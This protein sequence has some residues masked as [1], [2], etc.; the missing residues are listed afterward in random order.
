MPSNKETL[1]QEH[2]CTHLEQVQGYRR[3]RADE[4]A[5][6]QHHLIEA[7]FIGFITDTQAEKY[8]HIER[9]YKSD[10]NREIVRA[11]HEALERTPLWLLMR[12]GLTVRGTLLE[13][14]KPKPRSTTT[15]EQAAAYAQN[16]FAFKKEYLYNPHTVERVDLV[17]WLNGLPIIVV[18]L[19]HEDEGQNCEDA[20]Y[21]SFLP[22]DLHN[23]LYNYPFLYVAAS[24][25]EVKVAT[26]PRLAERFSWFNAALVNVAETEGEYPVEHLYRHA[27]SK[28]NIAKYLEHY[29]VYVPAKDESTTEGVRIIA[30]AKTLFPRYHQ[31][32]ASKA[33]GQAALAQMNAH[34][35]LGDRYLINHSAGSGKTFTIAW[36]ADVLDSLYTADNKKVYDNII[37]LTDRRSLDKNIKDDLELFDHLRSKLNFAKHSGDLAKFLEA[38]RDIIVST[39]HKFTHI[40]EK[41]NSSA[42]LKNRK[43]AFLIDEG[44]RSQDGKMALTMRKFF[45]ADGSESEQETDEEGSSDAIADELGALNTSNQTFV[46]FTATTTPKTVTSFGEPFDV[47]TEDEAIQEGYILDVAQQIISYETLYNLALRKAIPEKTFPSGTVSKLLKQIAYNDDELIQYKSEVIISLFEE[48]VGPALNG[49]AKAMVVASSRP[50]GM[51]YF[52]NLQAIIEEKELPYKVLFAFSDYIDPVTNSPVEEAVLNELNTTHGGKVIE[53]VFE[54]K[55]HRILVVANKFQTGFDQ[56]MLSAM[57]LD[58]VVSG[59]NAVQTVSRLNRKAPGK[60]QADILVVDFTNNADDIF[61][62]FNKH[63]KGSPYKE[64]KPDPKVLQELF[65]AVDGFEVYSKEQVAAYIAAY[66]KAEQEARARKSN[67]DALLSNINQTYRT[68]FKERLPDIDAQKN[69]I[70]LLSRYTKLYYF[71]AQFYELEQHLHEFI[72]F[73]EAVSSMLLKRGR[74]SELTQLMKYVELSKGAV[75]YEGPKKNPILSEVPKPRSGQTSVAGNEPPRTTIEAALKGILEQFTISDEEALV[76]R[77]ICTE[78]SNHYEIK[79][80]I[81]A[82]RE[83]E[84]YLTQTARPKVRQ[85]ITGAYLSRELWQKLEDPMYTDRGGIISLMGR[86]VIETVL[87][88][89]GRRL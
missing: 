53:E 62:A 60:E 42:L 68:Q 34:G 55:D 28:E 36:M 86:A 39:L 77:E 57:F 32:R 76:I 79:E 30:P 38:D 21:E 29:L 69:Y 15:P 82:N 20:I 75:R 58:K 85:E 78:V 73:A 80:R 8:A 27:F 18:E 65:D 63:R 89:A 51:K 67:A 59:V 10:T 37:I 9:D 23:A 83:N 26:D 17:L 47:Y 16:R 70:G 72:V 66:I 54:Q 41:L 88:N 87:L 12:Q 7:D 22:R 64:S 71:I 43:V 13:L 48:H 2:I 11:L 5:D 45:T 35:S 1:F 24:N 31:L 50:A 84:D 46:A 4:L 3:L 40:Q 61:K 56:P 52:K 19:K 14:Y 6:T 81:I 44:H 33:V 74:T 25:T 49:L